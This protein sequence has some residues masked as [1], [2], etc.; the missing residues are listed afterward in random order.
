MLTEYD[1]KKVWQ[2]IPTGTLKYTFTDNYAFIGAIQNKRDIYRVANA[3][4]KIGMEFEQASLQERTAL[5]REFS[6]VKGAY[7]N[8]FMRTFVCAFELVEDYDNSTTIVLRNTRFDLQFDTCVV[9]S[10]LYHDDFTALPLVTDVTIEQSTMTLTLDVAGGVELP[11]GTGIEPCYEGR[12]VGDS[13]VF[14]MERFNYSTAGLTF[15]TAKL[16]EEE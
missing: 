3:T 11:A 10:R 5:L 16:E 15:M 9:G 4:L 13:L 12:F 6:E 14:K 7:Y 2:I 8:F 1:G